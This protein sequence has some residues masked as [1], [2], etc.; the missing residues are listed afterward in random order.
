MIFCT[1]NLKKLFFEQKSDIF[2]TFEILFFF[3]ILKIKFKIIFFDFLNFKKKNLKVKKI[4]NIRFL[5]FKN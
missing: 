2:L 3:Y 5:T 1:K 4:E